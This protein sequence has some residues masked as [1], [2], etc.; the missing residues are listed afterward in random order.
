MLG[1]ETYHCISF[2]EH[3]QDIIIFIQFIV[4]KYVLNYTHFRMVLS[5]SPMQLYLLLNEI[6]DTL[7]DNLFHNIIGSQKT[8][9]DV[10]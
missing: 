8:S 5:Y 7:I 4:L 1:R 9:T 2:Y 10:Q 6:N 3:N